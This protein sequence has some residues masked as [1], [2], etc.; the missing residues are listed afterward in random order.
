MPAKT[1][2]K[3]P[4]KK[5]SLRPIKN[6]FIPHESNNFKA[7]ALH[8]S[9]LMFHALAAFFLKMFVFVAVSFLPFSALVA[10]DLLLRQ[11]QKIIELTNNI[12]E[13][14][15]IPPLK[16]NPQLAR[17]AANKAKDMSGLEYFSHTSPDGKTVADW[18]VA[19]GYDFAVS[20]E[21]LAVGFSLP[22][23][24]IAG[25]RKSQTH[26]AN[27]ID[28]NFSEIGVGIALGRY[29]EKETVYVAEFFATPNQIASSAPVA[30]TKPAV[31]KP[32]LT[33]L[34]V[35]NKTSLKSVPTRSGNLL[36]ATATL[37][38]PAESA[39]IF[40]ADYKIPL[41]PSP[42][43]SN[44]WTGTL[45]TDAEK[46]QEYD[47]IVLAAVAVK[48][49]DGK[50][51]MQDIPVENIS[52]AQPGFIDIYNFY[53]KNPSFL[54]QLFKFNNIYYALVIS[55]IFIALLGGV[56]VEIKH[57]HKEALF[58]AFGLMAFLL[59]LIRF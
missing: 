34:I 13:S 9:H 47:P 21:N 42:T 1:N 51:L 2:E 36:E 27:L 19:E 7:H 55:I 37:N 26:Y 4:I 5:S 39:T 57:K 28:E 44:T 24:I 18:I 46:K 35:E 59:I 50:I 30:K 31:T 43:D 17:A 15:N 41:Q 23:N 32:A 33:N 16:T 20:G 3:T 12:R 38:K 53:K 45:V 58:P 25:W 11:E 6:F 29:K 8:P 54:T 56:F 14:L 49:S 40:F 52:V 48:D 22:Q 10:P